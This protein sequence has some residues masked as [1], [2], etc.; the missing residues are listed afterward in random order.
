ML[1]P[2]QPLGAV[3]AC[4]AHSQAGLQFYLGD[5]MDGKR[6]SVILWLGDINFMW[7]KCVCVCVCVCVCAHVEEGRIILENVLEDRAMYYKT[8]LKDGGAWEQ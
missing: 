3:V 5:K 6:A 4:W 2:S 1:D 7:P 8:E